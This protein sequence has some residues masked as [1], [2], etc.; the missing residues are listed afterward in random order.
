MSR[1]K[2][3]L[4]AQRKAIEETGEALSLMQ[5]SGKT[6]VSYAYTRTVARKMAAEGLWAQKPHLDPTTK[7]D[8]RYYPCEA[9]HGG[10]IDTQEATEVCALG[11]P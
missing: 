6:R 7:R 9:S 3:L 1:K 11:K 10:C 5:L 2:L 4:E 8:T